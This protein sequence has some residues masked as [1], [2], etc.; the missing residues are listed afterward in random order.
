MMTLPKEQW[1]QQIS[2]YNIFFIKSGR[3]VDKSNRTLP[4]INQENRGGG[5]EIRSNLARGVWDIC[6]GENL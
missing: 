6:D 5:S 3:F 1:R 4:F 2:D